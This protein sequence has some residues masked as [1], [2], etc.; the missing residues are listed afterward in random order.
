MKSQSPYGKN[1]VSTITDFYRY[2]WHDDGTDPVDPEHH[3]GTVFYAYNGSNTPVYAPKL[4]YTAAHTLHEFLSQKTFNK[5]L[6]V[7]ASSNDYVLLFNSNSGKNF[8][9]IFSEIS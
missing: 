6:I 4:Q 7:S 5:R 9:S 3:F 1:S 8:P 2:D